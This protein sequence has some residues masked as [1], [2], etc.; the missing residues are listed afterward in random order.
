MCRGMKRISFGEGGQLTDSMPAVVLLTSASTSGTSLPAKSFSVWAG[1]PAQCSRPA[2]GPTI[3]WLHAA[4]T[5]TLL[6]LNYPKSSY[7]DLYAYI[8]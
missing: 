6:Y 4:T 1:T 7:D 8:Y 3:G 5:R 2:W